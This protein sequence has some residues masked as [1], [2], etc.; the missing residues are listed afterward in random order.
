MAAKEQNTIKTYKEYLAKTPCPESEYIKS[1]KENIDRLSYMAAQKQNTIKAYRKYLAEFPKG[2]FKEKAEL[3]CDAIAWHNVSVVSGSATDPI[4]IHENFLETCLTELYR[5][6]A[7][8]QLDGLYSDRANKDKTIENFEAYINRF[9][10]G[11]YI[12]WAKEER[13]RLYLL[14]AIDSDNIA[15]LEQYLVRFKEYERYS[16]YAENTIVR[17]IWSLHDQQQIK[18]AFKFYRAFMSPLKGDINF[19]HFLSALKMYVHKNPY[20]NFLS[21]RYSP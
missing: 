1:A 2:A 20:T 10:Q 19:R 7:L 15:E 5:Q 13:A 21:V 8:K 3:R 12:K 18:K 14:K 11:R 16:E 9:P 4:K 17:K 6:K